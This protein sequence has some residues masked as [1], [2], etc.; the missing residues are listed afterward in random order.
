MRF[1]YL[2]CFTSSTGITVINSIL[3]VPHMGMGE[4]KSEPSIVFSINGK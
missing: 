4:G 3:S 1:I 2:F